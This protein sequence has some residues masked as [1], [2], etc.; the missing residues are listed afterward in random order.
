[1]NYF[2]DSDIEEIVLRLSN[3]LLKMCGK[4]VLITGAAGFLGRYFVA[5]FQQFNLKT[6]NPIL[7]VA[8][9]NYITSEHVKNN[10]PRKIDPNIEWIYGD[11]AIAANLP[12][13]FDYV[14]HAAGIASPEHYRAKPLETINV[15]V[16]ITR[17]ILDVAKEQNSDRKSTR[18]NSSHVSESRMPSSA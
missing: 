1:M 13:K 15:A 3:S 16:N 18:L 8:L 4:K 10:D 12:D 9:D 7:I 5:V 2:I 14:L 11:A 6:D 17:D